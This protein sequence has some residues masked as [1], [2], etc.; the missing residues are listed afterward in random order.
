MSIDQDPASNVSLPNTE[1][2]KTLNDILRTYAE[3]TKFKLDL[4]IYRRNDFDII[5]PFVKRND[6]LV[7]GF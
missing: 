5:V 6:I 1:K 7:N 4:K 3:E 2:K